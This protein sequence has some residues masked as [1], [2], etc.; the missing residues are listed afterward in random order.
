MWPSRSDPSLRRCSFRKNGC[1]EGEGE[2][3]G[4]IGLPGC[5]WYAACKSPPQLCCSAMD[6]DEA[7][8]RAK[9]TSGD[10]GLVVAAR[11]RWRSGAG[12]VRDA[13]DGSVVKAE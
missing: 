4:G 2:T 11:A 8:K 1:G 3:P 7:R 9:G 12:G 6:V 10:D 13:L 5:S